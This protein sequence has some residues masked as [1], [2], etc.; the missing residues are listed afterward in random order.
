[1]YAPHARPDREVDGLHERAGRRL[2]YMKIGAYGGFGVGAQRMAKGLAETV[3]R[4]HTPH[5]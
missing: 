3:G 4:P 1:M 2:R 5:R